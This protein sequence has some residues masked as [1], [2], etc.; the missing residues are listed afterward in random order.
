MALNTSLITKL[1]EATGAGL[2][3]CKAALDEAGNDVQK[4]IEILRKKG[5]VKAAKK[6]A[7]RTT[8][9]GIVDSY[10]HATG[11]V[12]V[13]IQVGC[14]TD[15]VA[16]NA[17]FRALV[18][19][20]AIQVAGANAQ[21]IRPEDVPAEIIEKEKEIYREQLATEK[22]PEAMRDKIIEGKLAKFYQETCLLKQVFIKDDSITIEQLIEG[23]IAKLGEK[24]EVVR[25]SRFQ[26]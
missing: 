25:F 26:V 6:I 10:I 18:H 16:S 1:R 4:A 21:Y 5:A 2:N 15:F 9:E 20:L 19:D 8:H 14:E 12:G 24:I 3:D 17:D 23:G 13:L 11:K 22:K 7:E